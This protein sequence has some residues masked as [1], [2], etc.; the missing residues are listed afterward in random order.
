MGRDTVL[1]ATAE[2]EALANASLLPGSKSAIIPNAV[3]LPDQ[4]MPK[5]PSNKFRLIYIGRLHPKKGLDL[6]FEAMAALPPH[7]TLDVYGSGETAHVAEIQAAAVPLGNRVMFHGQLSDADKPEAFV[8]ADVFVLPSH[9]ENFGIVVAE[10]LAHG[11]PVIT[12]HNTPWDVVETRGCGRWIAL[13]VPGLARTI[14]S[15]EHADLEAMGARGRALIR[16]DYTPEAMG[17]RF[18]DIYRT[19][20]PKTGTA[21]C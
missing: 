8:R 5:V 10:A 7:V 16:D 1:H 17:R 15:L 19:L 13:T 2:A 11:T 20:I 14:Q 6:L 3:R 4:G 12:T 21:P 9:S 18:L